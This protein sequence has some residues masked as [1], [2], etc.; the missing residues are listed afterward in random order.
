MARRARDRRVASAEAVRYTIGAKEG[1]KKYRI[2]FFRAD[3]VTAIRVRGEARLF[4][5]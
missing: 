1:E 5:F 3:T 4:F 2:F